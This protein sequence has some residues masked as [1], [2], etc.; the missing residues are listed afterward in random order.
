[1]KKQKYLPRIDWR[2]YKQLLIAG[3]LGT[4]AILPYAFTIQ[5]EQ[6]A[7]LSISLPIVLI[8]S[9]LQSL[10]LLSVVTYIGLFFA[11]K[12]QLQVQFERG[13]FRSH[14][15]LAIQLGCLAGGL[16]IGFDMLF[17]FFHEPLLQSPPPVWQGFLAS[18][19]GGIT[20]EILLRLFFLTFIYWLISKVTRK[21]IAAWL[22]IILASILFGIGHLPATALL[23]EL[24][25]VIV[26]RA[27]V[28]NGMGGIIFGWL[29]INRSLGSAM[30][31]HFS[32][33]IILHVMWPII[34]G[35]I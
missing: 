35:L 24:T 27:I 9:V 33:D 15:P 4:L 22:A 17:S 14:G 30:V 16:I 23:T 29:Y 21:Q 5:G 19:Y 1:M 20:E 34:L 26:L 32:T 18:F 6:L 3:L 28:L 8:I 31:A 7:T 13:W 12:L 10:I 25:P 2:T 11:E